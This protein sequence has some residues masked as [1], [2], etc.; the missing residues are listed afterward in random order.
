MKAV[1]VADLLAVFLAAELV[2]QRADQPGRG[3]VQRRDQVGAALRA[4]NVFVDALEDLLD[5]LVEFG[6]VGDDQDAGI[7]HVLAN[8][9][10]EPD[11]R[12]ALAAS[13]ACAR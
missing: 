12:Q 5:L 3:G 4:V 8:P 11:H 9:L 10:G 6:A 2:D 1:D 7:L 13:P